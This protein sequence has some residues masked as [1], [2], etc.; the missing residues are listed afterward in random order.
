[1]MEKDRA[2]SSGLSA[3][4]VIGVTLLK[5]FVEALQALNVTLIQTP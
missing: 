4:L 2:I 3:S 1:M 5:S